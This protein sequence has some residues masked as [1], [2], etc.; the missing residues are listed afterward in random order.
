MIVFN[1]LFHFI[2]RSRRTDKQ[3]FDGQFTEDN[4]FFPMKKQPS[5]C[6]S[7]KN[8][9]TVASDSGFNECQQ[10]HEHVINND[11]VTQKTRKY[12][13]SMDFLNK[14][15]EEQPKPTCVHGRSAS[16]VITHEN[17]PSYQEP[18]FFAQDHLNIQQN[19]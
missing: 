11:K 17:L 14:S 13:N 3:M 15:A 12:S 7:S 5:Q 19:K 16:E 10:N 6:F 1:L 18:Q 2:F 4:N 8:F 9:K